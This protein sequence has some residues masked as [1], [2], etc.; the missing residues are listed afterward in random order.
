MKQRIAFAILLV[1]LASVLGATVFRDQV[2]RAAQ[3][4]DAHITNLDGNGNIKIHE[5]GTAAVTVSG[6]TVGFDPAANTVK[7]DPSSSHVAVSS[8]STAPVYTTAAGTP[9]EAVDFVRVDDGQSGNS[10]DLAIPDGKLATITFAAA[11]CSYPSVHPEAIDASVAGHGFETTGNG[12]LFVPLQP[13]TPQPSGTGF[14]LVLGAT[15]VLLFAKDRITLDV[16][17]YATDGLVGCTFDV[18]GY[19]TD[20]H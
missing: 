8:S 5:Q 9:F 11:H 17:R 6:G 16:V 10:D 14:D 1:G 12:L 4:V 13:V 19:L 2:A 7:L 20:A 18:A 3:S 15:Q